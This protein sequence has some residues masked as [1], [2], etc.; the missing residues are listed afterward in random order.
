MKNNLSKRERHY[1]NKL[2]GYDI[3]LNLERINNLPLNSDSFISFNNFHNKEKID[4]IRGGV[5]L[6][7]IIPECS[8]GGNNFLFRKCL[9]KV[10]IILDSDFAISEM[11]LSFEP[12]EILLILYPFS[13]S[14]LSTP[15]GK[16]SSEINFNL[17]LEKCIS[18]FSNKFRSICQNRKNSFFFK[19]REIIFKNFF[20]TYT[21]SKKL[22]NLP[23]HNSRSLENRFSIAYLAIYYDEFI[24]IYFHFFI[25]GKEIYKSLDL[26]FK[27]LGYLEIKKELEDEK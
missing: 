20:N 21:C 18:F 4:S 10:N 3:N 23:D 15:I 19:L 6:N 13:F 24:N 5:I 2:S 1:L 14:N 9:S 12:R 16:F 8:L 7:T 26:F 25:E 27:N 22:H 17:F 11:S